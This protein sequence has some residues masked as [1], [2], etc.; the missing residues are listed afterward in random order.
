MVWGLGLFAM[1]SLQ[2][3]QVLLKGFAGPHRFRF[4]MSKRVSYLR[5]IACLLLNLAVIASAEIPFGA[6]GTGVIRFDTMPPNTNWS[7]RSVLPSFNGGPV[8]PAFDALVQT[9]SASDITNQLVASAVVPPSRPGLS[10]DAIWNSTGKWIQTHPTG[11]SY[12]LL[13]ATLRNLSGS[14]VGLLSIAYNFT[15]LV[16][17]NSVTGEASMIIEDNPSLRVY[18][19]FSGAPQ[20]WVLIQE[21]G[22][23]YPG[24]RSATVNVTNWPANAVMYLL[25][26]DDNGSFSTTPPYEE[27]TYVIDDFSVSPATFGI[28]IVTPTSGSS[29]PSAPLAIT[30][31][32]ASESEILRVDF[33]DG[34]QFLGT[35][36]NAPFIITIGPLSPGLHALRS[37]SHDS[38]GH[39]HTSAEVPLNITVDPPPQI[40]TVTNSP[41]SDH[42]LV[43]SSVFYIAV[44]TDDSGIPTVD[45][46]VDGAHL[47]HGTK[48]FYG[49]T[50]SDL[51]VGSHT[52]SVSAFDSTGLTTTSNLTLTV[53]N[54]ANTSILLANRQIWNYWDN[55]IDPGTAWKNKTFD[56]R[57]WQKGRAPLGYGD[58]QLTATRRSVGTVTN[59][60][61]LFRSYFWVSDPS[62]WT[63]ILVQLLADDAGIVYI[64]G[65]EA[66]RSSTMPK[67]SIG[68]F[69][70]T[71][72]VDP[73]DGTAFTGTNFNPTLLVP[74]ENTVAVEV[75]QNDVHSDDMAFDLM[76]WG[77][78]PT[79]PIL[80]LTQTAGSAEAHVRWTGPDILQQSTNISNPNAWLDLQTGNGS[81]NDATI[82]LNSFPQRFFRTRRPT[83]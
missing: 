80:S 18:Y 16:F 21:L 17:S 53:T 62:S 71:G 10:G 37:I 11:N 51:T 79:R 23:D 34:S 75:H 25:W 58:S 30:A 35:V 74:G 78:G 63:N 13:M 22:A 72:M 43:G 73:S 42:A 56:D 15:S 60:A 36:T 82:D 44:V 9:N 38:S 49:L 77:V 69:G 2:E 59:A 57:S 3:I 66:Y 64:N 7:S 61:Q 65:T 67:G 70:F 19:S 81:Q 45:F 83:P 12:T 4:V 6:S 41:A 29:I 54:P 33:Y 5:L 50:V 68:F 55:A 14:N 47:A 8:G 27:G 48:P 26:A 32:A 24:L 31:S 76:I 46:T 1:R 20:S 28:S 39:D 52:V 40:R